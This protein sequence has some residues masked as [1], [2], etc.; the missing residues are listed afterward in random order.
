MNKSN[1]TTWDPAWL[2]ITRNAVAELE[3]HVET[4]MHLAHKEKW[5]SAEGLEYAYIPTPK[6]PKELRDIASAAP[7]DIEYEVVHVVD[8]V[9]LHVHQ[10]SGGSIVVLH[11]LKG[12]QMD[13]EFYIRLPGETEGTWQRIHGG[14]HIDIPAGTAHGFRVSTGTDVWVLSVDTPHLKE[15]DRVFV[16]H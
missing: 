10:L 6:L 2:S 1:N 7:C 4:A 11:P 14:E 8:S 13:A 5:G 3:R 9:P 12:A 16:T 15:S